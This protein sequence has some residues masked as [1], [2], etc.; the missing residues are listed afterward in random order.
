MGKR[1]CG[2]TKCFTSEKILRDNWEANTKINVALSVCGRQEK[3]ISALM[4]IWVI[5]TE[6]FVLPMKHIHLVTYVSMLVSLGNGIP[7]K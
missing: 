7:K 5:V 2:E 4:N 3:A 6:V 1:I